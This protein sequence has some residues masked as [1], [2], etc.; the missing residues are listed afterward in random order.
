MPQLQ[1]TGGGG[2]VGQVGVQRVVQAAEA[3]QALGGA[4]DAAQGVEQA[5]LGAVVLVEEALR[6]EVACAVVEG[7]KAVECQAAGGVLHVGVVDAGGVK[8]VVMAV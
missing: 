8:R 7:F 1:G 5:A 3:T 2:D 4:S 6:V